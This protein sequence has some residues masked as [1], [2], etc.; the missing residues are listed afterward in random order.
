[1]TASFQL[2]STRLANVPIEES[3]ND[4][5][6]IVGDTTYR[7]PSFIADFLSPRMAAL[8][9]IPCAPTKYRE[10]ISA[11]SV[12]LPQ[13]LLVRK[14]NLYLL[15]C[16]REIQVAECRRVAL[17]AD[18]RVHR[19]ADHFRLNFPDRVAFLILAITVSNLFSALNVPTCSFASPDSKAMLRL[20]PE[21]ADQT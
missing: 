9:T 12:F 21:S 3:R 8:H 15:R 10:T 6:F 17:R 5:E 1:M 4:F 14:R 16:F 2:S 7:C 18:H 20:F 11:R 13:E 19:P